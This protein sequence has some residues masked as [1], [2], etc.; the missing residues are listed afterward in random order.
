MDAEL[1]RQAEIERLN[2]DPFDVEAQQKIEEL[3][4]Q[5]AVLEN[6]QYAL[7]WSPESFGRVTM[8]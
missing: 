1:Q 4:R 2:N 3:I 7:E 5:E 6:M 8:L